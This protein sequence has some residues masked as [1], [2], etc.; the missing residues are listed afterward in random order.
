MAGDYTRRDFLVRLSAAHAAFFL[1]CQRSGG[2]DWIARER[3]CV[4]VFD[5]RG[6][7][8]KPLLE[9][10]GRPPERGSG[11]Y[12]SFGLP[13]L[14]VCNTRQKFLQMFQ[15]FWP[16]TQDEIAHLR[17]TVELRFQRAAING[18]DDVQQLGRFLRHHQ[19]DGQ[20]GGATSAVLLTY[21]D[22]TRFWTPAV[23]RVAQEAKVD[24]FVLFKN[25]TL[26]PYLCDYP[27]AQKGFKKPPR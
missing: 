2:E 21:N 25:P 6:P 23:I 15:Y 22:Y 12:F 1:G 5:P 9:N 20:P 3:V 26:P 7:I 27:A 4:H 19:S 24:E 8:P 14:A 18:A 10:P 17:L 13:E 11:R 16:V